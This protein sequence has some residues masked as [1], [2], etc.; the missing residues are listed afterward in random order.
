MYYIHLFKM[1]TKI[2]PYI[3]YAVK[4]AK[5]MYNTNSVKTINNLYCV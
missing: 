2:A 3:T 1:G 5:Y 4:I